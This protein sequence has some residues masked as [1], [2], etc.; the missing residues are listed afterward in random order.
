MHCA[1]PELHESA[2]RGN[3]SLYSAPRGSPHDI[4]EALE[5]TH[6][7]IRTN[8]V[9]GWKSLYPIGQHVSHINDVTPLESK[10]LMDW[11]L[12]LILKNHDLQV[13]HTWRNVD[14]VAIWDNRCML[15]TGTPDYDGLSDRSLRRSISVG[16]KPMFDPKSRSRR[17]ALVEKQTNGH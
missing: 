2:K 17:E 6:P 11:F 5:A 8:P 13:R 12:D 3:F 15:H 1:Q 9:T 10:A 4:G 16:E 14:D 7:V